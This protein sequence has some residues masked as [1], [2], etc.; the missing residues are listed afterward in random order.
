[1]PPEE[2]STP[3]TNAHNAP[4]LVDPE[5]VALRKRLTEFMAENAQLRQAARQALE[6]AFN[7]LGPKA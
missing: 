1:M 3:T 6:I 4:Q 5:I 2:T 7:A